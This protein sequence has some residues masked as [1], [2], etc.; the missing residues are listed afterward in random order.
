MLQARR[1][2]EVK[3]LP[4]GQRRVRIHYFVR[5]PEGPVRLPGKEQATPFGLVRLGYG[6]GRIACQP[7]RENI[8]PRVEA[9]VMRVVPHSDDPRAVSCPEC[10][11]TAQYAE[12]MNRLAEL[13]NSR[14]EPAAGRR[15]ESGNPVTA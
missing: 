1:T 11:A 6:V 14:V 10:Q 9:G 7:A 3:V 15:D 13:L 5:D 8:L 12:H 2:V 4:G